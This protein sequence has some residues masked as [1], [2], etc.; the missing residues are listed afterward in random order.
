M[1]V[2]NAIVKPSAAAAAPFR[3]P[4]VLI[5]VSNGWKMFSPPEATV[6]FRGYVHGRRD[7]EVA[8]QAALLSRDDIAGWL[9]GLDGH[10]SLIATA[11]DRAFAASDPVRSYPLIWA[12]QEGRACIGHSGQAFEDALTLGPGDIDLAMADVFALSGY[13]IGEATLYRGVR[14]IGPGQYLWLDGEGAA[15]RRY[16]QWQ[17]WTPD[18]VAPEELAA[19]LSALNEKLIDDLVK[20]AGGR[21]ILVPLSA[22]LDS[23]MMVSGLAAAGY[24]NVRC[25]AYG[26]PGNREAVT[27]RDVARR[28]GFDWQFV[29][30]TQRAM[31]RT[32]HSPDHAR[33]D[34]Y[35][36]SLTCVHFPQEYRAMT[37]LRA[38]RLLDRETI[39]VNGQA[40]DFIAGNHVP[41]SLF[42]PG[43]SPG[44]RM[45]RIL[46][47]LVD[48]HYRLWRALRT[49][50]RLARVR[51]LLKDEIEAI[52][53]LPED[54]AGDHG[55]YEHCEFQD[56]QSKYV[57]NGQRIY[58]YLELD[59]RLPLWDRAYMDF[60]EKAPLAAK[61]R[62]TLYRDVLHR[63]NWGGVWRDI[64]TNPTR[65]R[66]AWIVPVRWAAK[67]AHAPLGRARWHR[68]EKQ[69]LEYWMGG[70]CAFAAWPWRQVALDRRGHASAVAWHVAD[71]LE[72]KGLRWS[73]EGTA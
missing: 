61:K 56:R 32:F 50:E 21:P 8:S 14:Q 30:Y 49:P 6:W 45:D 55:V 5:S 69:H 36:D 23:R 4:S 2:D 46:T 73:G 38:R 13:T 51:A 48:K 7:E 44:Q 18:D 41:A 68:F 54:P 59:W 39:V 52:G 71:Y 20:S 10:Y 31:R 58:E 34:A 28:L 37:E 19:P 9:D 3:K 60:W 22:G 63:D 11:A 53:G 40:G 33:Y 66:P 25:F 27:S 43:G 26:L 42:D 29:P 62:E 17:P 70:T 57:L 35:S 64:P 16:H 67:A 12:L 47:A 72:R 1:T 15:V 24:Q 65:I